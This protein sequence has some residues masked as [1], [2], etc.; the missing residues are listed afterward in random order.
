MAG[1]R[2]TALFFL[3]TL[4]GLGAALLVFVANLLDPRRQLLYLSSINAFLV[5]IWFI[6]GGVLGSVAITRCGKNLRLRAMLGVIAVLGIL[7]GFTVEVRRRSREYWGLSVQH[8]LQGTYASAKYMRDRFD[9]RVSKEQLMDLST[10]GRWH[11]DVGEIY[12]RA[13]YVPWLA[14]PTL[15]PCGCQSCAAPADAQG[16]DEQVRALG[17]GSID[18]QR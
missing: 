14:L 12:S 17:R 9:P 10:H 7:L 2:A 16:H 3:G 1:F 6:T 8:R 4:V 13:A 5:G 18:C 11:R 15:V